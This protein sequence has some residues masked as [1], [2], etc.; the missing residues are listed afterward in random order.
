MKANDLRLPVRQQLSRCT[1]RAWAQSDRESLARHADNRKVWLNLKDIFPHPYTLEAA[2]DWITFQ[3]SQEPVMNFALEVDGEAAGGIGFA[4]MAGIDRRT[5]EFGYWLGEAHWNKGIATEAVQAF[6]PWIFAAFPDIARVEA[7]VF[8]WN[9]ASM[10][11]LEKAGFRREGVLR[12]SAFKD[13]QLI[14]RVIYA[15]LR[16]E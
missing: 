6:V 12:K 8:E 4:P 5:A 3:G 13:G 10:R 7:G 2:D 1:I 9:P 11:V 15:R 16:G 14:D